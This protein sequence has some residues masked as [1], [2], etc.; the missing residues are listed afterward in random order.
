[1]WPRGTYPQVLGLGLQAPYLLQG[2]CADTQALQL[3]LDQA[4]L[5]IHGGQIIQERHH[6]AA[7]ICGATIRGTRASGW[8]HRNADQAPGLQSS[9]LI[10]TRPSQAETTPGL[11]REGRNSEK[12]RSLDR[13]ISQRNGVVRRMSEGG[14][15]VQT[16]SY[17][18]KQILYIN[19]YMWNLEKWYR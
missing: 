3:R 6:T 16:S 4:Q 9:R 8:S 2:P 13:S 7:T 17:R 14:Q 19:T 5:V 1:M 12:R 15:K 11:L 10:H 18:E